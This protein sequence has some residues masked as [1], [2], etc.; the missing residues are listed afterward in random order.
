MRPERNY[1]GKVVP[2]FVMELETIR[3]SKGVS[4]VSADE[5]RRL[6]DDRC[7]VTFGLYPVFLFFTF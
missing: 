7:R 5:A 4:A 1:L 3:D 2:L 6:P